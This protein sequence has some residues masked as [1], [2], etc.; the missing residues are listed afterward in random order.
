MLVIIIFLRKS[1]NCGQKEETSVY[2]DD[3]FRPETMGRVHS[4][5]WD[6]LVSVGAMVLYVIKVLVI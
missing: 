3:S 2:T 6:S 4:V 5:G 1:K